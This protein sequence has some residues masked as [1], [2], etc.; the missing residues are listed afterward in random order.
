MGKP[1][2]TEDFKIDA[3]K[4]ITEKCYSTLRFATIS[5]ILTSANG[6]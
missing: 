6:E 2:F 1:R 4:K 3:I 5:N